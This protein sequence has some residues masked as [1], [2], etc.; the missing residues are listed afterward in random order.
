VTVNGPVPQAQSRI[1]DSVDQR[2][3]S[4]GYAGRE[5]DEALEYRPK[6]AVPVVVWA[7]RRLQNEHVTFAFEEQGRVTEVR[8]TGRL[9]DRAHTELTEALGGNLGTGAY[10]DLST[11]GGPKLT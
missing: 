7:I 11:G 10:R 6:F 9:R 3:R 5:K 4:A 1:H 2:L 8:V